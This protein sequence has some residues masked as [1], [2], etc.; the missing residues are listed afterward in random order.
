MMKIEL[1]DRRTGR[2]AK[3]STVRQVLDAV[4]AIWIGVMITIGIFTIAGWLKTL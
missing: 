3:R 2:R 4:V 1:R